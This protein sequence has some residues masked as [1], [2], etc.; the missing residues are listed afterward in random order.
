MLL[1]SARGA[2]EAA[3]AALA[4][5]VH[6]QA[7]LLPRRERRRHEREGADAIRRAERRARMRTLDLGLQLAESWLRDAWCVAE[8][9]T[10]LALAVDRHGE[11]ESDARGRAP[12]DLRKGVELV[13]ETRLRLAQ[14]VAEEL[15]LEALAY[16]LADLLAAPE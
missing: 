11:V 14:N 8:G 10:E 12:V 4:E 7:E 16:R 9:A 3:G 1:Q 6:E 2:G 15:A 5:R 13:G